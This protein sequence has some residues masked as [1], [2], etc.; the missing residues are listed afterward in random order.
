MILNGEWAA[1]TH[2]VEK[3]KE[4]KKRLKEMRKAL[5]SDLQLLEERCIYPKDIDAFHSKIGPLVKN[6]LP[7]KSLPSILQYAFE[8]IKRG[9]EYSAEITKLIDSEKLTEKQR[10]L[11]L[12]FSYLGLSEGVFSE[13]VQLIAFILIENHHDLYN[14]FKMKFVKDYKG[15]D[16]ITFFRKLQFLEEH[17]FKFITN[18]F[19][20]KLRNSIAH[21]DFIV[22]DD[23]TVVNRTNNERME[24]KVLN[25]KYSV[26][27]AIV[28]M[29]IHVLMKVL[30]F[31]EFG[32]SNQNPKKALENLK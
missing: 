7:K 12:L 13:C 16:D 9:N 25:A 8:K 1:M 19:D 6:I 27:D 31:K 11:L 5:K 29:I 10:S 20:R 3:D 4:L 26:L 2:I 24:Q 18:E 28:L 32:P 14:D 21:L 22:E 23:G 15:L 30:V 17:E